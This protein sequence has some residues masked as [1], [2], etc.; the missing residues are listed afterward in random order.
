MS[1][2]DIPLSLVSVDTSFWSLSLPPLELAAF[3][4]RDCEYR[5]Y[6]LQCNGGRYVGIAKG[7][8]VHNRIASHFA[9][10]GSAYTKAHTPSKILGVWPCKSKAV[11]AYVFYALMEAES[12]ALLAAGRLGGW[13]QTMA[14]PYGLG[15]IVLERECRMLF[16]Q[17]LYCSGDQF[18]RDCKQKAMDPMRQADAQISGASTRDLKRAGSLPTEQTPPRKLRA[19]TARRADVVTPIGPTKN[20]VLRVRVAGC[21]YASLAWHKGRKPGPK[22]YRR[23]FLACGAH[24]LELRNGDTKTLVR[25]RFACSP[26][27]RPPDLLP[28]RAR[29][30][31]D[32]VDTA[33]AAVRGGAK[34]QVRKVGKDQEGKVILYRIV[35]LERLI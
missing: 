25:Q 12:A 2:I 6:V 5:V 19:V 22:L 30:A 34:L 28:R 13:T 9:G 17:C 3:P 21:D 20:S 15:R 10:A 16:G 26:P 11:E 18:A 8:S 7:R 1:R 29:I 24:A 14:T 35:D 32:W 4:P 33:C 23:A 31:L 27:T